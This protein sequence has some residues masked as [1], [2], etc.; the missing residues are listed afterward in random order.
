MSGLQAEDLFPAKFIGH[1]R[2]Y[3]LRNESR[4][5]GTTPRAESAAVA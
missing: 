3:F 1:A 5:G 2:P 4:G